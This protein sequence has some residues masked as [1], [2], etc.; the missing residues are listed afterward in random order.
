MKWLLPF[1]GSDIKLHRALDTIIQR[2]FEDFPTPS[3]HTSDFGMEELRKEI[4]ELNFNLDNRNIDQ[5]Q[6]TTLALRCS[7]LNAY[8][9]LR[10]TAINCIQHYT[11]ISSVACKKSLGGNHC[12]KTIGRLWTML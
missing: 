10:Q 6:E 8:A 7:K 1:C 9:F 5:K 12:S 4:E 11:K 3:N 2:L